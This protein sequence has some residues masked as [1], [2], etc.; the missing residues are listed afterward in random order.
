[1]PERTAVF[2]LDNNMAGKMSRLLE[3]KVAMVTGGAGGIGRATSLIL[4]REGARVAISDV[5]VEEG[6]ETAEQIIAMGGDAFFHSADVT[7]EED[8]ENLVSQIV[9][10]WGR[11]DCAYNNAGI[12]G[13]IRPTIELSLEE[14]NHT[15]AVNM[16]S[17]WLCMKYQI[18]QMLTQDQGSIVNAASAAGLVGFP[19]FADYV[20]SKHGVV[21]LSRTAALEYAAM[22]IRV[23]CVCPGVIDTA[24]VDREAKKIPGIKDLALKIEPLGRLGRAE[25]VGEAVAWLCSDASSYVTGHPLAV[26]GGALAH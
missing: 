20:A 14:F 13:A 11:L 23:N 5:S 16:T 15:I 12:E 10:R 2:T 26:C 25:E 22:S 4:A 1:M 19:N 18:K 8:V 9:D 21:G 3:D 17:I 24:M 6:T 7:R